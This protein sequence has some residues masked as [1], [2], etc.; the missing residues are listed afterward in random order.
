MMFTRKTMPRRTL[1]RGMG[2]SIALPLMDAMIT[3]AK[4]EE[5]ALRRRLQVIYTPNGMMMENWTPIG[6]GK[7]YALSPILKPLEPYREKFAVFTGLSHVQAEALGDGA[8]DHGRCCGGYLTGVHVKKTEGA[9]ITSGISMDQLVAQKFGEHT[10]IP[11][12]ELGLEPPSL[13]GSCDS[14]YSCAYTNTLS[15][16]TASTPLPVTINPREVFERLFG[17]GDSL[18]SKSRL[19]QLKRQA[20]ILDFVAEDAKRMSGKLGARDKEKLSEYLQ[21]VRDIEKR[22]QK[23]EQGGIGSAALPAYSKPSGIPDSFED[24]AHMMID[25]QVLAMQADLTRVAT[26]MIGREVSGRSYPEIGVPDAHHPLS[27][28]GNDPEKIAKLT[29]IN[30]MHMEQ[31]AYYLKRMSES[32]DGEKP[33]L[34]N[35]LLLAGASLADPNRHDHR[36]LPVIVAG[37]LIAGNRHVVVEKDTPMT[38]MMLSLMDTLGVNQDRLGDSTGRLSSFAA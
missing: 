16:S 36:S 4:A 15:W 11:S 23:V 34:E 12:L 18:D 37:G 31:V 14:G 38:N 5:M 19:A 9:D 27:H 3:S 32:K 2:A 24:H 28:H 6:T 1:L 30:T 29:K 26:F 17:D 22:I 7:D 25:L 20:S 21:S 33:L 10:Q 13:V 35:T 8:G